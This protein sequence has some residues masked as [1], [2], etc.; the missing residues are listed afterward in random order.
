MPVGLAVGG[1]AV[2]VEDHAGEAVAVDVPDAAGTD[3]EVTIAGE[4]AAMVDVAGGVLEGALTRAFLGVTSAST[5]VAAGDCSGI[6]VDVGLRVG[7]AVLVADGLGTRLTG[8][9]VAAGVAVSYGWVAGVCAVWA[10]G[11]TDTVPAGARSTK[12]GA[13]DGVPDTGSLSYDS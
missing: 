1:I 11:V 12:E 9:S 4:K 2:A 3:V 10:A 13:G 8:D 7:S 6:T 5:R